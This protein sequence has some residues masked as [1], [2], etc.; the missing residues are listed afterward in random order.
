MIGFD[1]IKYKELENA[2]KTAMIFDHIFHEFI[3]NQVSCTWFG[4]EDNQSGGAPYLIMVPYITRIDFPIK[5]IKHVLMNIDNI[6]STLF[7]EPR[8]L[9]FTRIIQDYLK[10]IVYKQNKE[11]P[12]IFVMTMIQG[13]QSCLIDILN[14]NTNLFLGKH[15]CIIVNG[16]LVVYS[17]DSMTFSSNNNTNRLIP[18]TPEPRAYGHA[19]CAL[20]CNDKGYIVNSYDPSNEPDPLKSCSVYEYN[21]KR[22]NK[23]E[24][25]HH[26]IAQDKCSEGKVFD[27][28]HLDQ[29]AK[30]FVFS[31]NQDRFTFSRNV[32]VNSFIFVNEP[33][34]I[35]T[36]IPVVEFEDMHHPQE[37][38]YHYYQ[39]YLK[40][41]FYYS[42]HLFLVQGITNIMYKF[43]SHVT[44]NLQSVSAANLRIIREGIFRPCINMSIYSIRFG[45]GVP[46]DKCI[47]VLLDVFPEDIMIV[48][49]QTNPLDFALYVE[50]QRAPHMFDKSCVRY[51]GK[52]QSTRPK[53]KK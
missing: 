43:E 23:N 36:L 42:A 47:D 32:G 6:R 2:A 18:G 5:S 53:N 4:P 8:M 10:E 41:Y 52:Q 30:H 28:N 1:F 45:Q 40:P 46:L 31:T 13:D 50:Y 44:T 16:I 34:A 49:S 7:T 38:Q 17:L 48:Q 14:G 26:T 11:L 3:S 19:I 20:T 51:G 27:I 9:K 24:Y 39:E 12:R 37:P 25:Y 29:T 33:A 21:W 35:I 15:V 22:W